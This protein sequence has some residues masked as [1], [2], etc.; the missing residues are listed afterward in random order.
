MLYYIYGNIL[1]LYIVVTLILSATAECKVAAKI[2]ATAG[3]MTN[4]H[5][6]I[7]INKS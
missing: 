3:Q 7:F 2:T 1:V 5:K 6:T 4:K